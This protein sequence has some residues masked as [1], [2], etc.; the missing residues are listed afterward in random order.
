MVYS[1]A[2]R[3]AQTSIKKS[4]DCCHRQAE[5]FA[6]KLTQRFEDHK[7]NGQRYYDF[8]CEVGRNT[9]ALSSALMVSVTFTASSASK[10][11]PS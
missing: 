7:I 10:T 5:E 2:R 4:N 6:Q 9:S 1:V 11:V 3:R 8:S